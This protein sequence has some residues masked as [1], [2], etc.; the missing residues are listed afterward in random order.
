MR[1]A[2]IDI[3]SRAIKLV[4]REDGRVVQRSVADTGSDPL[5]VCSHLLE[6]VG[7]DA[8][9]Y[10]AAGER[11]NDGHLLYALQAGDR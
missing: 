5:A 7:Y 3:G 9:T 11:L 1:H 10:L 4:V 8:I 2:G 6:G